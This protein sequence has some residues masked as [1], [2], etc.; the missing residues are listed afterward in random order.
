MLVYL[1]GRWRLEA[2]SVCEEVKTR[3]SLDEIFLLC[4]M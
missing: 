3:K 1:H 2:W 4:D